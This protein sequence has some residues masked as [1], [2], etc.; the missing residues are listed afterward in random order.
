MSRLRA[1][2]ETDS[3]VYVHRYD[4][5]RSHAINDKK[6]EKKARLCT[7]THLQPLGRVG[8]MV[9]VHAGYVF[10]LFGGSMHASSI[11]RRQGGKCP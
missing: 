5:H 7:A 9:Q 10:D 3:V 6:K 2:G 11:L 1:D 8:D 4:L